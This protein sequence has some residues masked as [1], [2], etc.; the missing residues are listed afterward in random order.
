[1]VKMITRVACRSVAIGCLRR[2]VEIAGSL[3]ARAVYASDARIR[4]RYTSVQMCVTSFPR[5]EPAN[6]NIGAGIDQLLA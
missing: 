1:M 2:I 5:D 4:E 3:N 6:G